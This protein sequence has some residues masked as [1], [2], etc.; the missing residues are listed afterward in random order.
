MGG[1]RVMERLSVALGF[2]RA[3]FSYAGGSGSEP[4]RSGF[5]ALLRSLAIA[6][7]SSRL[8][9]VAPSSMVIVSENASL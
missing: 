8:R 5:M 9:S 3:S 6:S 4:L 7:S 1:P 2:F